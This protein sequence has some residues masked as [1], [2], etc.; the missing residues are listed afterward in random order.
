[1][2]S[3]AEIR[4]GGLSLA[5]N[6]SF[7]I[8]EEKSGSHAEKNGLGGLPTITIEGL[9][10]DERATSIGASGRVVRILELGAGDDSAAWTGGKNGN[11]LN[12]EVEKLRAQGIPLEV[13]TQSFR[14]NTDWNEKHGV[15][16]FM[17]GHFID[18]LESL[19]AGGQKYDL[20][21]SQH[22]LYQTASLYKA[23]ELIEDLLEDRGTAHLEDFIRG[24][25]ASH[26][27]VFPQGMVPLS[28]YLDRNY[29]KKTQISYK[30]FRVSGVEY[31]PNI[32]ENAHIGFAKGNL[33]R[34]TLPKFVGIAYYADDFAQLPYALYEAP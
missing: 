5:A 4:P 13:T 15:Q 34:S 6:I 7:L 27:A 14:G 10:W 26:L 23:L 24:F 1:M 8:E 3:L 17:S 19:K 28:K 30:T 33:D 21:L 12:Y 11:C 29:V 2:A 31:A 22:A 20:I 16:H 9:R 32:G 18:V 25:G